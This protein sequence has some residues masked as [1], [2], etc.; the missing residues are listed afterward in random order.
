MPSRLIA[1]VLAACWLLTLP[2]AARAAVLIEAE[3]AEQPLRLVVD[4]AQQRVLLTTGAT[5]A[6]VDL[7]GGA[8]YLQQAAGP[9]RRVPA[10]YRPGYVEPAAYRV[11]RFGP[12]P[13]VAG[14]ASTYYVLFDEERVCAEAMLNDWMR[15]FVDPAVRALALLEQL[16]APGGGDACGAIPFATY[17]AAGWPLMAGKADRPTFVTKAIR[18]DYRPAPDE[19]ALPVGSR[20]ATSGEVAGLIGLPPS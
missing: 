5:R 4:R 10:R 1:C 20:D 15:P 2:S 18:F 12:G 16:S 3:K 8:I 19:L 17:A 14:Q 9:T 7:A 11:E 13:M 6:L